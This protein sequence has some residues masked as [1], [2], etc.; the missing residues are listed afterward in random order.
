MTDSLDK[1]IKTVLIT[2]F[3]MF[4]NIKEG[5]NIVSEDVKDMQKVSIQASRDEKDTSEIKKHTGWY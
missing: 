2:I 1:D 4:R 5:L 3:Y